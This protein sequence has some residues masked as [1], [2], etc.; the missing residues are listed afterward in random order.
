[1]MVAA[2]IR[3]IADAPAV[4]KHL[5]FKSKKYISLVNLSRKTQTT[6]GAWRQAPG[7]FQELRPPVQNRGLFSRWEICVRELLVF[8]LTA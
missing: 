7:T 1:M 2:N 6:L 3:K 5:S 4:G 8:G